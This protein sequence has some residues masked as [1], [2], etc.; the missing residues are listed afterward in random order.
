MVEMCNKVISS[1]LQSCKVVTSGLAV[2]LSNAPSSN[3]HAPYIGGTRTFLAAGTAAASGH[4]QQGGAHAAA[5][6]M[7]INRHDSNTGGAGGA[8]STQPKNRHQTSGT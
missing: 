4:W 2:P 8:L 3:A 6:Y 7:P 5:Q 1:F